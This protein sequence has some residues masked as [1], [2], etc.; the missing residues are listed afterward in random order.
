MHRQWKPLVFE[1]D[2]R[3][4]YEIDK[5]AKQ[6]W[7]ET[8]FKP[9]FPNITQICLNLIKEHRINKL[10]IDIETIRKTIEMYADQNV[11][12]KMKDLMENDSISEPITDIYQQCFEI[13]FLQDTEV[14]Y[15]QQ[16]VPSLESN[17]IIEYLILISEYFDQ[18]MNFGKL[19]LPKSKSTFQLLVN[20]L[21]EIF[22]PEQKLSIIMDKMKAIISNEN[23]QD[24]KR[25]YEPVSRI[26][27]ISNQVIQLIENHIYEN[28]IN[29]IERISD[30][31]INDPRT[32]I[33]T[34]I[35]IHKKFL[36]TFDAEPNFKDPL[37]KACQKFTNNNAVTQKANTTTKSS[38]LLAQYCDILLRKGNK[39]NEET[40]LKEKFNEIMIIFNYI[41]DKDIY[42]KF[43]SKMLSKRLI[44]QLSISEDSEESMISKLKQ[45]C[46]LEYTTKLEQKLKDIRVSKD[47]TD[48]YSKYCEKKQLKYSD[49]FSVMVLSS[50]SWSFSTP[51]NI[52][53]PI[54]LNATFE[55]FE[56]F[57]TNHHNGRKLM[58]LHQYSKGELQTIFINK[59]YTLEV[60]TY[61]M[62]I[63]LS[64]N[65]KLHWTVEEIQDKTQI[66]F[67]LLLQV[68]C[69]LLKSKILF[70]K[71]IPEDFQDDDTI[72]DH[73][74][75]LKE[76][77]T[78]K[79]FLINLNVPLKSI[80]PKDD[81]KCLNKSIDDDRKL[82]IQATIVRIMKQKQSLKHSLLMEEVIEQLSTR[83]KPTI[84]VIEKCIDLLI[85]KEYLERDSNNKD[86][87]RYLA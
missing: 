2:R 66:Q 83:F 59:T 22:L 69:S 14:F 68:L 49:K 70:S 33:E 3:D 62:I 81:L 84:P 46:G 1:Q 76:D 31:A 21:E 38:E 55:S 43:Y 23:S 54:E 71:E 61:Q 85:E 44:N 50:N 45:T 65:E 48:D 35:D 74:I 42:E 47:L 25:V 15:R 41:E 53:L 40:N 12:N 7:K 78:S 18:E 52:I 10:S 37:N 27:N 39:I 32:Y 73:I 4:V 28:G 67:K 5:L 24:L 16:K 60:S 64:F 36:K 86:I 30:N 87:L 34:L 6:I 63:L 13:K 29:T 75:E 80:K 82:E 17:S 11:N 77:F 8:F 56:R 57:Y 19:I 26:P 58:W 20:K 51:L 9:I 72:K 79:K